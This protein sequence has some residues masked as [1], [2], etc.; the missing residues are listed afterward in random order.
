MAPMRKVI[1]LNPDI[2]A[3]VMLAGTVG[4]G[5]T[6]IAKQE[7]KRKGTDQDPSSSPKSHENDYGVALFSRK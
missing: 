4:V 6:F 7:A 1:G 2:V 5:L 3:L